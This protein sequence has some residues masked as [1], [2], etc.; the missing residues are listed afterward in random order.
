MMKLRVDLLKYATPEEAVKEGLAQTHRY[1]PE[2]HFSQTGVGSL[3]P[4]TT[5]E[6]AS[7]VERS[8]ERIE[9]A[10]RNS[11]TAGTRSPQA[12]TH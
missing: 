3:S 2:P 10:I 12:N 4:A 5:S 1:K 9:N 8:M 11:E 7:E 6:C